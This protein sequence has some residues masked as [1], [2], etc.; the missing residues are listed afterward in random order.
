MNY[1]GKMSKYN[2]YKPT[3]EG[4][5]VY[6]YAIYIEDI[7]NTYE[8][9]TSALLY[10]PIMNKVMFY[11]ADGDEIIFYS[12]DGESNKTKL[13][14]K[15]E[16]IL[17]FIDKASGFLSD[18]EELYKLTSTNKDL[19]TKLLDD[20]ISDIDLNY[21]GYSYY[22]HSY[23]MNQVYNDWYNNYYLPKKTDDWIQ[24]YEDN[25]FSMIEKLDAL[26]K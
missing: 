24:I 17:H 10:F 9:V 2:T 18:P 5:I 14:N 21:K 19:F 3:F 12:K 23:L 1:S 4:K 20:E 15:Q 7:S 8:L 25:I 6:E 11:E 16:Q 26:A 13:L 22:C